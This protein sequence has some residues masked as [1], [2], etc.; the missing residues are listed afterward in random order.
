MPPTRQVNCSEPQ[1]NAV[2]GVHAD[3]SLQIL[4]AGSR[5]GTAPCAAVAGDR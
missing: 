4:S 3:R 1:D 2:N 5:G